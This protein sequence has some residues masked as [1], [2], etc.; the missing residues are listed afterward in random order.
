MNVILVLGYIPEYILFRVELALVV[1][2]LSNSDEFVDGIAGE[3][4][5]NLLTFVVFS[6]EVLTL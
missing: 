1:L 2:L 5:L 3:G 4:I 6:L